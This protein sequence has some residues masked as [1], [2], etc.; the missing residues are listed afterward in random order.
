[1]QQST[2]DQYLAVH[3]KEGLATDERTHM[4]DV[5]VEVRGGSVFLVGTVSCEGRRA[6]AEQVVR[7]LISKQTHVANALRVEHYREPTDSEALD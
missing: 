1:M 4:L 3:I 2:D 6:S 5:I 7:E